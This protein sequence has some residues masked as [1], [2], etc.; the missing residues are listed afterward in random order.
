MS[1]LRVRPSYT[2]TSSTTSR[3]KGTPLSERLLLG[4]L[5]LFPGP[6]L[7]RKDGDANFRGDPLSARSAVVLEALESQDTRVLGR[8]ENERT[9]D[10]VKLNP[11]RLYFGFF[12]TYYVTAGLFYRGISYLRVREEST[13]AYNQFFRGAHGI[14][15]PLSLDVLSYKHVFGVS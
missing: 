8:R 1:Y 13:P 9:T 5:P 10:S 2:R 11:K 7:L 12:S 4:S 14:D 3:N 15:M 6:L